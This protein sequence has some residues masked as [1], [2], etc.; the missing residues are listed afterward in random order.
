MSDL[1]KQNIN[2]KKRQ[3]ELMV[4]N[5]KPD[6]YKQ[7]KMIDPYFKYKPFPDINQQFVVIQIGHEGQRPVTKNAM[8]VYRICGAFP[9]KRAATEYGKLVNKHTMCN[10]YV[11]E[12][13]KPHVLCRTTKSQTNLKYQDNVLG[14]RIQEH[15]NYNIFRKQDFKNNVS[16]K[17]SGN[18]SKNLQK[19]TKNKSVERVM[20]THY[21]RFA[22][23]IDKTISNKKFR[24]VPDIPS[25]LTNSY[26]NVAAISILE[27]RSNDVLAGYKSPEPAV[28]F[29]QAFRT[30]TIGKEWIENNMGKIRNYDVGLVEMY[31]FH[32]ITLS[33][34]TSN[35][36]YSNSLLNDIM[37]Y[38]VTEKKNAEILKEQ[39]KEK[40]G[41]DINVINVDPGTYDKSNQIRDLPKNLNFVDGGDDKT[42]TRYIQEDNFNF[43]SYDDTSNVQL[44]LNQPKSVLDDNTTSQNHKKKRNRNRKR[45]RKRERENSDEEKDK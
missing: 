24:E 7:I 32:Y 4:G 45:K 18:F 20:R 2:V 16:K 43:K 10:T 12:S 37:K 14:L 28:I 36:K 5:S 13:H 11:V 39:Y 33:K 35:T 3:A 29:W 38:K 21:E 23:Q 44:T 6:E 41:D 1:H 42:K 19:V 27:D 30:E 9:S 34:D 8:P 31:K 40:Y 26:H 22:Q 15:Q 25:N 17:Q